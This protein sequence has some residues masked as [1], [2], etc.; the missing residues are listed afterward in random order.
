MARMATAGGKKPSV[1]GMDFDKSAGPDFGKVEDISVSTSLVSPNAM[2]QRREGISNAGAI[3]QEAKPDERGSER[4]QREVPSPHSPRNF[5]SL[6]PRRNTEKKERGLI[7]RDPTCGEAEQGES[8]AQ[9]SSGAG[10]GSSCHAEDKVSKARAASSPQLNKK[11]TRLEKH[12]ASA[13]RPDKPVTNQSFLA[14]TDGS[15]AERNDSNLLTS[16]AKERPLRSRDSRDEISDPGIGEYT[17]SSCNINFVVAQ[18][19]KEQK[20]S[21]EE[22]DSTGSNS[23][24]KERD[25]SDRVPERPQFKRT[26]SI[27][28]QEPLV[29]ESRHIGKWRRE[30]S[31]A[32]GDKETQDGTSSTSSRHLQFQVDINP[33][34]PMPFRTQAQYAPLSILA[35]SRLFAPLIFPLLLSSSLVF[36]LPHFQDCTQ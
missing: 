7:T 30:A 21:S 35:H 28:K 25:K 9:Q 10:S 17:Y 3:D 36:S 31:H 26:I 22:T 1:I 32:E 18:L 24:S 23:N 11:F 4:E 20:I 8:V 13:E 33:N 19:P 16:G 27:Q 5:F 34:R 12:V 15:L 6:S 14:T 2:T 29:R